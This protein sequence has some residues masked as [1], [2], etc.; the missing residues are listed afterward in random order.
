M[1]RKIA[2]SL[3]VVGSAL[4]LLC[5][6]SFADQVYTLNNFNISGYTGPFGE[7]DVHL[8]DSTHASITFTS[9]IVGGNIYLF[10]DGGSAGVNVNAASWTLGTITGS[11]AGTGFAAPSFTN[12]GAGNEDG[13]GS[14]NQTINNFDGFD[15][16]VDTLGFSITNTSGTWA[17]DASV[18]TAN[19]SG[20]FVAAHIFVTTSPANKDNGAIVT[21]FAT[22]G[23]P[24]AAPEPASLTLLGLGLIGVP[25][26]RRRK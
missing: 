17:N 23:P 21:G 19:G 3:A 10:G 1:I 13:W 8:V 16:A 15:H 11:N 18:L 4:A 12:G 22:N 25:F 26:L 5:T 2:L 6:P 14:F 24:Q 7:V 20:N 9:D